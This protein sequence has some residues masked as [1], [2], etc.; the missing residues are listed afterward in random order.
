MKYSLYQGEVEL[1]FDD[2]K[3][4]YFVDGAVVPGVTGVLDII[5]KPALIGWAVKCCGLY[6][7]KHLHPGTA[8]DEIEI[9]NLIGDMKKSYRKV[10][11]DAADI[12]SLVHA[13]CE[14][15]IKAKLGEATEPTLPFN[16]QARNAIEAFLG[17]E[18]EHEVTYI[19][20]E[21]KIYSR[22]YR[23]AGTMDLDAIIDGRR[24]VADFKTSTGIY[25]EMALQV[26]LYRQAREEEGY[27]PYEDSWIIRV[28]KDGVFESQPFPNYEHDLA[29]G[30]AALRLHQWSKNG[31]VR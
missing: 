17:W 21:C 22:K 4:L 13:W 9:K 6:L 24:S 12:G 11:G 15:H 3:H 29:G 26:A 27:G 18:K 7:E 2:N 14:G 28:G 5:S 31:I 25:R 16:K 20:S 23:Y 30:L 19:A 10:S 1:E 8:Y